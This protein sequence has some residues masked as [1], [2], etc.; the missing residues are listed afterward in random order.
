MGAVRQ[1]SHPGSRQPPP[2]SWRRCPAAHCRHGQRMT[3]NLSDVMTK[4]AFEKAIR[5][6]WRLRGVRQCRHSLLAIARPGRRESD[7]WTTGNRAGREVAQS[8]SD[9]FGKILM[10]EFFTPVACL[11]SQSAWRS[12][13]AATGSSTVSG[14]PIGM[15]WKAANQQQ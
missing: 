15:R 6:Q 9:A 13:S 1:R 7:A 12:G 11:L 14:K 10:E 5:N 3:S 2:A 8:S 4:Q